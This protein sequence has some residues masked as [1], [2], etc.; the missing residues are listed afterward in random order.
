[1]LKS[2]RES[3]NADAGDY[4]K[5]KKEKIAKQLGD[6][7]VVEERHCKSNEVCPSEEEEEDDGGADVGGVHMKNLHSTPLMPRSQLGE[8]LEGCWKVFDFACFSY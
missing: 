6:V 4:E 1:M 5:I 3:S 8:V 2:S 7:C